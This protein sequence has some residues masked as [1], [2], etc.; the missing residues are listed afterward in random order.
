MKYIEGENRN[1]MVLFA[2]KIDDLISVDNPIRVIDEFI[3]QLDIK[4]IGIKGLEGGPGRPSYAPKALLKLYIYCNG[5]KVRSS[6]KIKEQCEINVEVMWLM[7]RLNPDHRTISDFRKENKKAIKKVFTAFTKM[8][9]EIGIYKTEECVQDGSKFRAVNSKDRNMTESKLEKRVKLAEEEMGKYLEQL[10]KNDNVEKD[11]EKYTKEEIQTKIE[12]LKVRME[13]Y[14]EY[15]K[16]MKEEGVT[17]KS[18]TDRESR[19]MKTSNGGFDVSYN[20]QTLVDSSSHIIG[21]FQVTNE[22]NDKGLLSELTKEAKE[23]LGIEI[24]EVTADKGYEDNEDILECLLS[25]TIAHVASKSEKKSYELEREYK[26]TEL[27]E[28]MKNSTKAEDIRG[29]IE[30]GVLP[31]IYE[32]KGIEVTVVE[33]E[34]L[35]DSEKIFILNESGTAVVCPQGFSLLKV[36]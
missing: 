8:C 27:T 16:E 33:K 11:S 23:E 15:L 28:E 19:L 9:I 10:D 12:K 24:T 31:N 20:V 26:E 6:R 13:T 7:C 1:Q 30:A 25:G 32:G 34:E 18:S 36:A 4:E 5:K 2:E 22:C 35:E 17:Q 21:D 14:R 3:N 29:C